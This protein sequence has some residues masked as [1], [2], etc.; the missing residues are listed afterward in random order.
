MNVDV[1]N[2]YN[3]IPKESLS[4]IAEL[5]SIIKSVVGDY[6]L[7]MRYGVPTVLK[8]GHTILH[9]GAYKEFISI[10]PLGH[11]L[12]EKYESELKDYKTS[13]GTIQF[14]NNQ[15]LPKEIIKNIIKDCLKL[16]NQ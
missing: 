4:R 13:R 16:S 2:Y 1:K 3:K 7:T 6:E 12:I 10:Y 5:E 15:A 14:Q 11:V 8:D 9:F